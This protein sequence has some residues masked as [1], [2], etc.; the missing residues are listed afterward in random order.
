MK[1]GCGNLPNYIQQLGPDG[2]PYTSAPTR[3]IELGF[4]IPADETLHTSLAQE[5]KTRG[6]KGGYFRI[7]DADMSRLHYV[8]PDFSKDDTHV[9]WYSDVRKPAMPGKI[10]NAGI[11]CGSY[12]GKPFYH[13][14]GQ[15]SDANGKPAMGHLLPETCIPMHPVQVLG[16][17]FLDACFSRVFDP[18]TGFELFT[19]TET[20]EKPAEIQAELI[21]ITPNIEINAPLIECCRKNGWSQASVHGLGSIIGAHF[22]DGR[23]LDSFATEFLITKGRVDLTGSTVKVSLDITL[24]G[25]DGHF[26]SGVSKPQSNPVLITAEIT[27]INQTEV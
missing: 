8:I 5:I 21:R 3:L 12:N 9:A 6:L 7:I 16:Y 27:L 25:F 19:P 13:C 24:V 15:I 22:A 1:Q 23:I 14:H 11:T 18:Q 4:E 2:I 26:K 20:S 17:G 10:V